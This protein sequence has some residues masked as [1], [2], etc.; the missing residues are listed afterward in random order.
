[1]N[2]RRIVG[3]SWKAKNGEFPSVI[4]RKNFWKLSRSRLFVMT[5]REKAGA[6]E[7]LC[8]GVVGKRLGE[9]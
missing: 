9:G 1:M 3:C 8:P 4:W 2:L 6:T 7:Y 5:C